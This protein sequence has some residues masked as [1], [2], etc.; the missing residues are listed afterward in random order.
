VAAA[1]GRPRLGSYHGSFADVDLRP[2]LGGGIAGRLK[3]LLKLKRWQWV[4]IGT[5][6]VFI[7]L[8]VVDAGIAGN[9]F[10]FAVDLKTGRMLEDRSRLGLVRLNDKPGEGADARFTQPGHRLRLT[11]APGSPCYQVEVHSGALHLEALLDASLAPDPLAV[12]MTVR[13]GDLDATQKTNLMPVSGT[14]K[15]GARTWDLGQGFAGIDYTHGL[16]ARRTAWQWAFGMGRAQDATPIGV[17]LTRGISD[18]TGENVVW[19]GR[20]IVPV[21]P[22]QFVWDAKHLEAPWRVT[23]DD[24]SVDLRFTPMGVHRENRDLIVI[25]SHFAQIGG[26]FAGTVRDSRGATYTVDALPGVAEDQRV[27][28]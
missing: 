8:A 23:T 21:G 20:E 24:G 4:G 25:Q 22:A 12:L 1:R 19:V 16:F 13:D 14:L 6:E 11:R 27:L 9:A 28:W 5:P 3:T 17:N 2:R 26:V 7:G 15:V 18:Q 10:C